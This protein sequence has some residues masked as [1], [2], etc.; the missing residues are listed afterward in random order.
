[1]LALDSV[2]NVVQPSPK[3]DFLLLLDSAYQPYTNQIGGLDGHG[4]DFGTLAASLALLWPLQA[5]LGKL[6]LGM[7]SDWKRWTDDITDT[8]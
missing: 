5:V 2:P 8:I 4:F 6:E 3:Y 1:M 7:P